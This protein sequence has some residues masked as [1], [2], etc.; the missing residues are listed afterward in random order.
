[1]S[2]L[3][4]TGD[5]D[6]ALKMLCDLIALAAGAPGTTQ[7]IRLIAWIDTRSEEPG[8][9]AW[10]AGVLGYRPNELATML[11]ETLTAAPRRRQAIRKKLA[12]G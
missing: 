2:D 4:E 5:R 3:V 6:A 7:T 8:G 11:R 1:L 10:L 12:R 9:F